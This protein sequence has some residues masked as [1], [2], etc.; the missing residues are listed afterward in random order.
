LTPS[1]AMPCTS[2]TLPAPYAWACCKLSMSPSSPNFRVLLSGA[3]NGFTQW[4]WSQTLAAFRP[5]YLNAARTS[6]LSMPPIGSTPLNPASFMTRY[7][8]STEPFTPIV[9]YMIALRRLRFEAAEADGT[10]AAAAAL[11]T[12]I[13]RN[14]RRFI[15][16]SFSLDAMP[17]L[18]NRTEHQPRMNTDR[19][20]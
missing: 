18:C 9:E 20:G 7:F 6:S 12:V 8:S 13:F 15:K 14:D 4:I 3:D 11:A 2:S 5:V 19:H 10:K 17:S 1:R 16:V